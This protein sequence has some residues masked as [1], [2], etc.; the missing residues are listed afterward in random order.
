MQEQPAAVSQT[1]AAFLLA[2]R[3]LG[4]SAEGAR[5]EVP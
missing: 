5:F 2:E 4:A 3:A 1:L